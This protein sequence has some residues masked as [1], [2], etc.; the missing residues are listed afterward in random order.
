MEFFDRYINKMRRSNCIAAVLL[1]LLFGGIVAG[2][3]FFAANGYNREAIACGFL[4]AVIL[5]IAIKGV[6]DAFHNPKFHK[7]LT[8]IES[9]G[10]V[11]LLG[12]QL[13]AI[14][15]C[16][17]AKGDLRFNEEYF[18]YSAGDTLFLLRTADISGVRPICI[19]SRYKNY[20]VLVSGEGETVQIGTT[21][22]CA[23][24]LAQ[25]IQDAIETARRQKI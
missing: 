1:C 8:S 10:P 4:A 3:V 12:E 23:V 20:Y 15:R 5:A 21:E 7:F 19:Q 11:E 9:M 22:H 6:R 16:E 25:S 2:T 17:L 24:L 14:K 18:F 13:S